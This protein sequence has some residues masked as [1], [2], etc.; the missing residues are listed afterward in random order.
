MD[1]VLQRLAEVGLKVNIENS[2]F[3]QTE[4]EYLGF[5]VSNNG[6]RPLSHKVEAIKSIDV[7]TKLCD[8]WRFVGLVNYYRYMWRKRAH[9]LSPLTKLFSM[10]VKF[11]WKDIENNAFAAMTKIVGLDVLLSYPNFIIF[12]I[13]H[14]EASNMKLEGIMS[15]DGK[16]TAF[17]SRKL[18]PAQ[19]NYTKTEKELLI[20][21]ETLKEF[22]TI[23][24][25]HRITVYTDHKNITFENFTTERVLR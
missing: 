24:L 3:G 8:V 22:R 7:P 23:F 20:I 25:G 18:T 14:T 16:P 4:T 2:F 1:K 5:W 9:T 6:L 10:K 11:K 15:Q 19:I 13:I 17:Y 12:K 21:V